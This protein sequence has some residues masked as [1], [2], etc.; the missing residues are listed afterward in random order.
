MLKLIY[1]RN[2]SATV[3]IGP[4]DS[5]TFFHLDSAGH[6][7]PLV[8]VT[9]DGKI[10][11]PKTSHEQAQGQYYKDFFTSFDEQEKALGEASGL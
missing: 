3:P 5:I 7:K 8:T 1:T 9:G 2:G 4:V 6:P 10:E 11:A